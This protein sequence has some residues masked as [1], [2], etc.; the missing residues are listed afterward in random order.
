LNVA[1]S[2]INTTLLNTED[3]AAVLK[4]LWGSDPE[5]RQRTLI[6]ILKR[7]GL[8]DSSISL[9]A[10]LDLTFVEELAAMSREASV[11]RIHSMDESSW[12]V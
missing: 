10:A 5:T 1:K 4:A 12:R 8:T 6:G 11:L 2:I 3:T 9:S 7:N